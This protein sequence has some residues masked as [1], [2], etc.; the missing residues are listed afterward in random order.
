LQGARNGL[1]NSH[2]SPALV[3]CTIEQYSPYRCL[4][5]LAGDAFPVPASQNGSLGARLQNQNSSSP[6][7]GKPNDSSSCPFLHR[8]LRA[9]GEE[10]ASKRSHFYE[11][12]Q[13]FG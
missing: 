5:N 3:K 7:S 13:D 10:G 9:A 4:K 8:Q 1:Q 6:T 11:T 2:C 12:L